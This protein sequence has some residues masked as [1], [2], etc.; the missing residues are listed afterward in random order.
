MRNPLSPLP[1]FIAAAGLLFG[2][3]FARG[4]ARADQTPTAVNAERKGDGSDDA[5]QTMNAAVAA[6]RNVKP[7]L[8]PV[9]ISYVNTGLATSIRLY[10]ASGNV[11]KN[12]A[13]QLDEL[14]CDVRDPAHPRTTTLDR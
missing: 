12:A 4:G 5:K 6:D 8:W 11:D 7:A 9:R 14:L 2:L 10:D 13:A 3:T 1:R